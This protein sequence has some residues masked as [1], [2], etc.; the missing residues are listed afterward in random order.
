MKFL[1]THFSRWR[2]AASLCAIFAAITTAH[3]QIVKEPTKLGITIHAAETVNPNDHGQAAPIMVRIYEL[4]SDEIFRQADF[5]SLQN[6]DKAT[7][8]ADMLF[9][10][11]FILRPGESKAIRRK[12]YADTTAIGVLA[13]YRDLPNATWR[14]I[15]KLPEAP[16]AAWYRS[17]L[18]SL[19]TT[20]DIELRTK[21]IN[22][23]D[24]K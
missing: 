8:G 10:D 5:L 23:T 22:I 16:E 13:G 19:K 2:L 24:T 9:K 1:R 7:L 20:L 12:S 14:E 11:E 6:A 3:A 15:Y 18:P 17:L 4:K 21:D